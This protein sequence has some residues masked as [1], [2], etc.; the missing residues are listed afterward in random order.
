MVLTKAIAKAAKDPDKK[1][2]MIQAALGEYS[3]GNIIM[4]PEGS[5]TKLLATKGFEQLSS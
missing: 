1:A 5:F 4:I 3:K 2:T